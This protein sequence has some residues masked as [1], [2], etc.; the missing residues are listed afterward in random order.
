MKKQTPSQEYIL[1]PVAWLKRLMEMA[2]K[3]R[4]YDKQHFVGYIESAQWILDTSERVD[5][6]GIKK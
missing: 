3:F 4:S 5:V 1:M 6:S 2:E